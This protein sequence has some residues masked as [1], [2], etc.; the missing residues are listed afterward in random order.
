MLIYCIQTKCPTICIQ[1]HHANHHEDWMVVE[2]FLRVL[3]PC[4]PT[5]E[6]SHPYRH[7]DDGGEAQTLNQQ[8]EEGKETHVGGR[9]VLLISLHVL[10]S[11][12]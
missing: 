8:N 5:L 2:L 6:M 3:L 12:S 9:L 4:K 11:E 10:V 7:Q 1:V